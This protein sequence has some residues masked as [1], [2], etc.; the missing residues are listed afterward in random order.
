[1]NVTFLIGN[2]FDLRLGLHT[3][4]T[5]M[6]D[7]YI[8]APS[9]DKVVDDF[10]DVL[11][12]DSPN[13]Y[14]T[15]GDFE[16]AMA[17]HA[18][19]FKSEEELIMCVRDFKEYMANHL[20]GEQ[21]KFIEL[22]NQVNPSTIA[23]EMQKSVENF[24]KGQTPNIIN[25]IEEVYDAQNI[26]CRFITFNYTLLLDAIVR[27]YNNYFKVAIDNTPIH[28]HGK[29]D[30]DIVLGIDNVA[31]VRELPYVLSKRGERAF[32]KTAFNAAFDKRRISEAVQLIEDSDVICIYGMSLGESDQTWINHLRD[33]L[34]AD[35]NHH[36]IYY[37]YSEKKFSRWKRDEMMDEEDAQRDIL[38][39]RLCSEKEMTA[40][41]QQ[42]HIPINYD[43]FGFVGCIRTEIAKSPHFVGNP[44]AF[45]APR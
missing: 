35:S 28:I 21:R 31:Q 37:K 22:M 17:N 9:E 30:S 34:I 43:I 19:K 1:M 24:Y 10:K 38:L 42:V 14:K 15:W 33:W 3:K 6:Y 5:D 4:Y 32:V 39:R 41:E 45:A 23:R 25:E 40:L 18:K 2:G 27:K 12:K 36:L 13:G 44:G 16:M 8:A 29:F 26:N 7:G 11:K 20:Q